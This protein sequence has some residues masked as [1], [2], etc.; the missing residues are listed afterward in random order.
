MEKRTFQRFNGEIPIE[1]GLFNNQKTHTARIINYSQDGMC[2]T[3]SAPF[4]ERCNIYFRI[5]GL[6]AADPPQTGGED[7]IRSVSLAEVRW[8][9]PS[10]DDEKRIFTIGVKYY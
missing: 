7:G 10:D 8:L 6:P 4:K 5:K 1:C 2:F 3:C 9:K